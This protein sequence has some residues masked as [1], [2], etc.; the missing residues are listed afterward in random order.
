[1][2]GK[3]VKIGR[4][5]SDNAKAAVIRVRTTKE[6][7]AELARIA[8]EMDRSISWVVNHAVE[9]FLAGRGF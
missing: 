6:T 9:K 3:K 4:P 8:G 2:K 7:A 5:K 1:M